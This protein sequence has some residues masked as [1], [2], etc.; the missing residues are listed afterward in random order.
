MVTIS[1]LNFQSST[2]NITYTWDKG[3][4][5]CHTHLP[6]CCAPTFPQYRRSPDLPSP[7]N[8]LCRCWVQNSACSVLRSRMASEAACRVHS[9]TDQAGH[10]QSTHTR[11]PSNWRIKGSHFCRKKAL[12]FIQCSVTVDSATRRMS[13]LYKRA[14]FIMPAMSSSKYKVSVSCLTFH[15]THFH[16]FQTEE[17][18][19]QQQQQHS[20]KGQTG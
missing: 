9:L 17:C 20:F 11:V 10:L 14:P 1:L 5:V 15:T 6:S 12:V 19:Q 18:K 13:I 7:G 16:A 2:S 3:I 4:M 8:S